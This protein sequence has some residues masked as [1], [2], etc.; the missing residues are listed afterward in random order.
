M[1][2]KHAVILYVQATLQSHRLYCFAGETRF[3]TEYIAF[4]R[5]LKVKA[6]L[7]E[8]VV[9]AEFG[10]WADKQTYKAEAARVKK[11]ILDDD[12]WTEIEIMEKVFRKIVQLLRLCDSDMPTLGKVS[13]MLCYDM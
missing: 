4:V 12:M 5:A 11:L 10:S 6:H 3:Y 1:G 13:Q 9:S 7:Q 2:R 8:T